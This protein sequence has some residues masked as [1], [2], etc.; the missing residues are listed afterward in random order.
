[1]TKAKKDAK[2]DVIS[3]I[4]KMTVLELSELV[5]DLEGKFN[6][7]AQAPVMQ[8]ASTVSEAAKEAA[9]EKTE[10]DAILKEFGDKKIQVIKEVRSITG[11]GLK[12]A[13]AL[14]D[15]VPKPVKEK[16]SKE[17]AENIKKQLE[18]VGAIVEVK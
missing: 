1:M 5:K 14:V 11:L 9:E 6:V 18:A 13:K 3:L 4:E 2:K 8:M 10:F 15:G 12:E 7:K 16:V 17:D